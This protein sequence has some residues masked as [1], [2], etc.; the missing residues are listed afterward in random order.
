MTAIQTNSNVWT[1]VRPDARLEPAAGRLAAAPCPTDLTETGLTETFVSELAIKHLYRGGVMNLRQLADR[2]A[3]AGSV[4]E[5][6]VA[7]LRNQTLVEVLP[8]LQSR[9]EGGVRYALTERGRSN[10]AEALVKSGYVGPAPVTLEAYQQV[11]KSQSVRSV[12]VT[13]EDAQRAFEDVV[14]P[15]SLIDR[16]GV[17]VNSGRPLFLYGPPGTGKTHLG[18]RLVRLF[19][20]DDILVPYALLLGDAVIQLYDPSVHRR[21]NP[22]KTPGLMLT[23]DHDPRFVPC[24][25]PEVITGGELTLD[26]LEVQYDPATCQ[27]RAPPSLLANNGMYMIDDLGRQRVPPDAFLNRWIM[28]MEEGR[29][30]LS[31]GTTRF[32]VPFDVVLI[33]STNMNP[34][35]LADEAFLRRLG[36]KIRFHYVAPEHYEEIWKRM[37]AELDIEFSWGLFSQVLELYERDGRSLL[38][39]HPRDLLTSIADHLRYEGEGQPQEVDIKQV[40]HAWNSYFVPLAGGSGHQQENLK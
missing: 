36:H 5:P 14:A 18:R 6:V 33:F 23:G 21:V 13:R 40:Q 11:V 28:P 39:C 15:Q 25:R 17:G 34:L 26:M 9:Q 31:I 20:E 12:N 1:D 38:P 30:F 3:L 27:Y 4:L 19:K 35:S 8:P 10:A 7:F 37:C 24:L 29:D 22:K 2:L 16:L 32:E